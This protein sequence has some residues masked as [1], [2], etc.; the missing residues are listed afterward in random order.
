MKAPITID[1]AVKIEAAAL[2]LRAASAACRAFVSSGLHL[3]DRVVDP[4]LRVSVR[5][6]GSRRD[7][8]REVGAVRGG[9]VT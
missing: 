8:L 4:L 9:D 7:Q 5:H 1:S 6:A 3:R 2:A